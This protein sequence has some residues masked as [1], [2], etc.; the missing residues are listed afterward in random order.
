MPARPRGQAAG[1]AR[2]IATRP[3]PFVPDHREPATQYL[4]EIG[5]IDRLTAAQEI[6]LGRRIEACRLL[7]RRALAGLPDGLDALLDVVEGLI[8]SGRPIES[9]LVVPGGE[10]LTPAQRRRILGAVARLRRLRPSP[11]GGR[12]AG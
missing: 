7:R 12:W 6:E 8:T 2:R 10:A 5:A 1:P 11:P 9:I 3:V 4:R